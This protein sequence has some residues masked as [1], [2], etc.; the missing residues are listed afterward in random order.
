MLKLY[1]QSLPNGEALEFR[2]V[3]AGLARFKGYERP[4]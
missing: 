1:L 2:M 4:G 3:R